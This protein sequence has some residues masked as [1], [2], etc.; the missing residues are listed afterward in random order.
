M[1]T[2]S[3]KKS[4]L[5]I[6]V[7]M[8]LYYVIMELYYYYFVGISY[9][10]FQMRLEVNTNK[11]FE[12]KILFALM[13]I[14]SLY[15]SK[16]SEF[17]YAVLIFFIVSF[18]IPALV[19]Y[20]FQNQIPWPL[21]STFALLLSIGTISSY[22]IK[23]I[24]L[25]NLYFSKSAILFLTT[26]ILVP[27]FYTFG[28]YFNLGNFLLDDVYDTRAYFDMNSSVIINYLYN[29][30]V[31]AI[32]PVLLVFFLI[33]KQY[34]F[35]IFILAILVYLYAISGNKT[36]YITSFIVLFFF[37][38][39][40]GWLEKIKFFLYALILVLILFPLVDSLIDSHKL[41]GTFV[42]R[43]LFLPSHL[44]YFYFDL[45][46]N[47]PLYFAESNF[48]KWFVHYP[49]DRPVGFIIAETYFSAPE[50]NA[51]NGII[52]DGYMNLGYWG[53]G[54]N[55]LLVSLIFM[56]FNSLP[57]DSRYLGI[58]FLLVFLLAGSPMLSMFITSG[59]WILILL[60]LTL[61][62]TELQSS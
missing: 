59:L 18:F 27:I 10:R 53:V 60:G 21:Y 51:N 62:K 26:L 32:L 39:G 61:K 12:T 47:N 40:K 35:A 29:W 22:K 4:V 20:S 23:T 56:F 8:I 2:F 11:Y 45:F 28:V 16:K 52:S 30:L 38:F 6:S 19:N 5:S 46:K 33:K 14:F 55:I 54:L 44:D 34:S 43:L 41:K 58:F 15:V 13:M 9:E 49:F 3:F 7:A 42:M 17:I 36:V 48:F 25:S 37:S 24:T 50:M 31:R 57:V 1:S